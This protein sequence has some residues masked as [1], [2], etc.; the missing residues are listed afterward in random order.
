MDTLQD[1]IRHRREIQRTE[2]EAKTLLFFEKLKE[3]ND[4]YKL[5][6]KEISLVYKKL[7][8]PE[9]FVHYISIDNY[10]YQMK[11]SGSFWPFNKIGNYFCLIKDVDISEFKELTKE[12]MICCICSY[13]C[14]EL[15][16]QGLYKSVNVGQ[17]GTYSV[18]SRF[19]E[20]KIEL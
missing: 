1:K 13:I 3:S 17:A 10:Y 15:N 7:D 8:N 20:I 11:N 9:Y 12:E 16:K 19:S 4:L 5:T 2:K 18:N 14:H 6:R